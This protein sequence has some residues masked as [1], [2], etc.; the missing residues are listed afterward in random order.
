MPLPEFGAK[1]QKPYAAAPPG[2]Q[3]ASRKG[4]R[5]GCRKPAPEA[6]TN[7]KIS[8]LHPLPPPP[9]NGI[10]KLALSLELGASLLC[11][12]SRDK[13]QRRRN[14]PDYLTHPSFF[15][16]SGA[17]PMPAAASAMR[18]S[19]SGTLLLSPVLGTT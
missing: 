10:K 19:H 2:K 15:I 1:P 6:R 13:G 9:K 18:E 11:R 8:R 3:R 12:F 16:R 7:H 17:A 4:W 5:S 14:T